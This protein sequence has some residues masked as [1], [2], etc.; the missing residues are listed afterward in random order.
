MDD[1][2][3]AKENITD[4]I[5]FISG[6]TRSG[7]A[8]LC[9]IL[10]SF[11]NT[12]KV[13]VN[14][15]LEQIP[16]LNSLE[17]ISDETATY[18]LKAGMNLMVYDNAI[19]RNANFRPDDYTSIW[20]YR[21]PMDYVRRLFQPDGDC[22]INELNDNKKLFPMMVHNGLWHANIWFQA[23][24]LLKIIHM[25]RCPS[26]IVYSWMGKDYGD[27]FFSSSRS[28]TPT[29]VYEGKLVP[30]YA[31]GWEEQYLACA[32]VDRIILMINKIRNY[33]Q[34][35]YDKLD[36]NYKERI[37]F[38]RHKSM[39]TETEK[40]L[41]RISG[42]IGVKPSDDTARALMQER[43]PRV[44]NVEEKQSKI[45]EIRQKASLGTYKLLM[46]MIEQFETTD[47]AI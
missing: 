17:K 7:K 38:V 46:D 6:L 27:D 12:E 11:N 47:L 45:N 8:L 43:C 25:Q 41:L 29:Y 34:D 44:I 33:H 13:S 24:P 32:G 1:V 3:L 20:K 5:V 18:L 40:N 16:F 22:V 19:G 15:F 14:F 26:E 4:N 42:F 9:P 30:Y 23:F 28:S 39:L 2:V 35:S 21:N 10:S 36:S 37:L 31:H